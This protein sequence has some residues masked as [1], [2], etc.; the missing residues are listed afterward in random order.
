MM[1]YR[2]KNEKQRTRETSWDV[3]KMMWNQILPWNSWPRIVW[4]SQDWWLMKKNKAITRALCRLRAHEINN[5]FE[6]QSNSGYDIGAKT[7][8]LPIDLAY[9]GSLRL[10]PCPTR[11]QR[12]QVALKNAPCTGA[13]GVRNPGKST[14][15]PGGATLCGL[16][17]MTTGCN[18]LLD[19]V[20]LT[21]AVQ[22][23]PLG[24]IILHSAQRLD[25]RLH[26]FDIP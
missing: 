7:N 11:R 8:Y 15:S 4:T 12:R 5:A 14:W 1:Q 17:F 24:C 13:I 25:G 26:C 23:R 2:F 20:G 16:N 9:F 3:S 21:I 22:S 6:L 10:S 18:W 19:V